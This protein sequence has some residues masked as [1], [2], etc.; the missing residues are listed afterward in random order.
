MAR[1]T[2]R[3]QVVHITQPA[4]LQGSAART[5]LTVKTV[6]T[7]SV[8]NSSSAA[9][10][11]KQDKRTCATP[12]TPKTTA[13]RPAT[14]LVH[15]HN[16]VGLPGM[17]LHRSPDQQV[18]V[19]AVAAG[20]GGGRGLGEGGEASRIQGG[21]DGAEMRRVRQQL[22]RGR[23]SLQA[24][25]A[26]AAW[27]SAARRCAAAPPPS[28]ACPSPPPAAASPGRGSRG[29]T[30]RTPRAPAQTAR[31]GTRSRC[32]CARTS[33]RS[34]RCGERKGWA[35]RGPEGGAWGE[36]KRV[37]RTRSM[38]GAQAPDDCMGLPCPQP[39]HADPPAEQGCHALQHRLARQRTARQRHRLGAVHAQAA[40]LRAER[41]LV[42]ALAAVAAG[43]RQSGAGRGAV[44]SGAALHH[45]HPQRSLAWQRCDSNAPR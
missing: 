45:P 12:P 8:G 26:P 16:V 41:L 24:A 5:G 40:P 34:R 7:G 1:H 36:A 39:T 38:A 33:P 9:Y 18:Q 19:G 42:G 6:T 3:A 22:Q 23:A 17:P 28:R 30:A 15:R 25:A 21:W 20:L 13:C 37:L 31:G 35:A 14:H 27:A 44:Q 32:S 29:G 2:Q 43:G 10:S 4:A 11:L